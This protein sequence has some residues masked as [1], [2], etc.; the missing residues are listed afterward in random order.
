VALSISINYTYEE[1]T[2]DE[3]KR[4]LEHSQ[5]LRQ[6]FFRLL[7]HHSV[8]YQLHVSRLRH[9]YGFESPT[10]DFMSFG[11]A[12]VGFFSDLVHSFLG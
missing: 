12:D 3:G 5:S 8:F 9:Q 10:N 2:L 6:C 7:Y 1:Y 11:V 4:R